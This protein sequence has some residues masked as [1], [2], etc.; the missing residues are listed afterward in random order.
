MGR[1]STNLDAIDASGARLMVAGGDLLQIAAQ[2]YG[3]ASEWATLARV[4]GLT[5]PVLAGVQAILIPPRSA[6]SGGILA[7][8]LSAPATAA[9][10]IDTTLPVLGHELDFINPD[11]AIWL[12]R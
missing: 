6:N 7:E 5:D 3:D 10:V 4:N 8:V 11:N 12:A 1:M 2:V 9:E